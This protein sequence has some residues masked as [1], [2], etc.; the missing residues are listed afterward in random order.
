[1][2]TL[3]GVLVP[4][5]GRMLTYGGVTRVDTERTSAVHAVWLCLPPLRELCWDYL[6]QIAPHLARVQRHLLVEAG[7]PTDLVARLS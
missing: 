6:T 7:V 2:S 4:Q 1:M 5:N 3:T